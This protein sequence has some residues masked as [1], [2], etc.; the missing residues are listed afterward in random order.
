M[1]TS[2]RYSAGSQQCGIVLPDQLLSRRLGCGDHRCL[3][4][5]SSRPQGSARKPC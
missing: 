4:D 3:G 2:P 1:T 5:C